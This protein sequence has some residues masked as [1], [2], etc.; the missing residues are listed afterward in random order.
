[1]ATG[2]KK[3]PQPKKQKPKQTEMAWVDITHF[4]SIF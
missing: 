1:M 4:L 3:K 2:L